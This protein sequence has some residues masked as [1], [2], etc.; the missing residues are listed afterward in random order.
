M[1]DE[2]SAG[3][4]RRGRSILHGEK[5]YARRRTSNSEIQPAEDEAPAPRSEASRRPA[6]WGWRSLAATPFKVAG[7]LSSRVCL[8]HSHSAR[9]CRLPFSI[10]P[11]PPRPDLSP[12][13]QVGLTRPVS[14]GE[15]PTE[16]MDPADAGAP[17]L[18]AR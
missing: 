3:P 13:R 18:P 17:P 10:C 12:W 2:G 1:T 15:K 5:P 4:Q 6:A 9:C 11:S 16:G 8:A 14:G 7:M